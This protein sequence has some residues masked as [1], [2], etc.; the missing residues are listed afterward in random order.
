MFSFTLQAQDISQKQFRED[1]H[2]FNNALKEGHPGLYW[3]NSKQDLHESVKRAEASLDDVKNVKE[4]QSIFVDIINTISCGH[5]AALLPEAHFRMVDS[6]NLFLPFNIVLVKDKV[7][8][9]ESFT[10]NLSRGD[11]ILSINGEPID[12]VIEQLQRFIPVD[13]NITTKRTR[14]IE[15]IFPYN[16]AVYKASPT[17]F[18][19]VYKAHSKGKQVKK[20]LDSVAKNEKM[21]KSVRDFA[22][23]QIPIGLSFEDSRQ[24]A[25]LKLAT[26]SGQSF[27]KHGINFQDT[28]RGVFEYLE[29]NSVENLVIDLRWNNGG[30]MNF[31]EYLFSFFIDF[32]YRYYTDAEIK[33][34]VMEGIT[35]FTRSRNMLPMMKKQFG[36]LEP[37]NGIYYL[38]GKKNLVNPTAPLFKGNLYLLTNGFSFSATSAFIAHIQQNDFA[39]IIGETPGGAFAGVNAGPSVMVELPNSKIRLYYRVIGSRYNVDQ[40]K[41]STKV[42]VNIDNTLESFT[43]GKDVQLDY[44]LKEIEK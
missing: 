8:V 16:Y 6:I 42:D 26:F 19:I 44:V 33:Q 41:V 39:Q 32:T 20:V 21:Y 12:E 25:I 5:T 31:A 15:I 38:S 1:F 37:K 22:P 34:P 13:K 30:S 9:S 18:T 28:I 43:Q 40:K 2:Y 35:K 10:N 17:K 4:L 7:L 36:N 11:Q 14:S 24:T 29:N 23:A 27:K 3:F